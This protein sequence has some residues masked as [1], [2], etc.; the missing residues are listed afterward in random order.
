MVVVVVVVVVGGGWWAVGCGRWAVGGLGRP[1][2]EFRSQ[3]RRR[4][5][6]AAAAKWPTPRGG[7]KAG[8]LD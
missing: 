8:V 5:A 3:L 6:A 2:L 7:E 4:S 1:L